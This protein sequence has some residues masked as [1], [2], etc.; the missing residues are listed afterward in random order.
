MEYPQYVVSLIP[1]FRWTKT[2]SGAWFRLSSHGEASVK[3]TRRAIHRAARKQG[4]W[5]VLPRRDPGMRLN[6]AVFAIAVAIFF[7]GILFGMRK[8]SILLPFFAMFFAM[9]M[10]SHVCRWKELS[11][12]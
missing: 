5:A 3:A 2:Y 11:R 9:W 8:Y 10:S 1:I 6:M 7:F 4:L 12:L